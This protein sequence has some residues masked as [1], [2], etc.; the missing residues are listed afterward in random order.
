MTVDADCVGKPQP[1]HIK[2]N[3]KPTDH[4]KQHVSELTDC[5]PPVAAAAAT[6]VVMDTASAVISDEDTD[7]QTELGIALSQRDHINQSW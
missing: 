5:R 7:W 6:A 2:N 3:T 1:Q 4:A